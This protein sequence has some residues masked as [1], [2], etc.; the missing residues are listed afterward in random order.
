LRLYELLE[1]RSNPEKNPKISAV[2][3]I[4]QYRGNPNIFVTFTDLNKVGIR[5]MSEVNDGAQTPAGIYTYPIG[6]VASFY[7]PTELP[8]AGSKKF[9]SIIEIT[10]GA[11]ILDLSSV[12]DRETSSIVERVI[13]FSRERGIDFRA[14]DRGTSSNGYYIWD[15][16]VL[17]LCNV[18][19]YNISLH[20]KIFRYCGYDASIRYS[21]H[22]IRCR[23]S[24]DGYSKPK[25]NK[26]SKNSY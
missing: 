14:P 13:Q 4:R 6:Y 25:N 9:C 16:L 10:T 21:W 20:N 7:H 18:G 5:P 26:I 17:P 12:S 23:T 19:K 22:N 15:E 8:Y 24:T 11:K 2:D 3:V 1:G